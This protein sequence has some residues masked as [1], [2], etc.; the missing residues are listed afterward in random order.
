MQQVKIIMDNRERNQE[1]LSR[2]ELK[3]A[4]LEFKQLPVG[5]YIVS[6]R[7]CI[8]RKT[9]SDLKSS[10][11][12]ARLFDQLERLKKSFE[13]P[14]LI[15]ET[16]ESGFE[17]GRNI[18]LGVISSLYLDYNVQLILSSDAQETADIIYAI[19]AREQTDKKKQPRLVGLKRAYNDYQ[20]QMLVLCSI[21]G[22]GQTLARDLLKKFKTV[23]SVAN[24]TTKEL[25]EVD[26]IG[27]KKAQRI[28]DILNSEPMRGD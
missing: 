7:V 8:E 25:M 27:K 2:L 23:K 19:A 3:N 9:E 26:K 4:E 14:I 24:A 15:L 18:L 13:K 22:V 17:L 6:D 21:P 12:N 20:W 10:V 28:Y 1:I 5:D 11:I 16:S